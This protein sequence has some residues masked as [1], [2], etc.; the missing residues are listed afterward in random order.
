[1]SSCA[2]PHPDL[3][4]PDRH[5][6]CV[7]SPAGQHRSRQ[8]GTEEGGQDCKWGMGTWGQDLCAG[9]LETWEK[10]RDRQGLGGDL[11]SPP[12]RLKLTRI[13]ASTAASGSRETEMQR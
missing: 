11:G 7:L 1:M 13:M 12:L 3:A 10:D 2:R 5:A 9:V 6:Y 4:C 8:K